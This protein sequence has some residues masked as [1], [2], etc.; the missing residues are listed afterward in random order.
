M[1]SALFRWRFGLFIAFLLGFWLVGVLWFAAW[2]DGSLRDSPRLFAAGL[3]L[4]AICLIFIGF[5]TASFTSRGARLFIELGDR[6]TK[7]F[8]R[9]GKQN[10]LLLGLL[11]VTFAF[12]MAGDYSW[13]FSSIWRRLPLFLAYAGLATLVLKAWMSDLR[14]RQL[15]FASLVFT[16]AVLRLSVFLADVTDYPFSLTWSETTRF[17]YASLFFSERLYGQRIAWP[18]YDASRALLQAIPF[19]FSNLP[20][21]VHRLWQ[22][23]LWMGITVLTANSLTRRLGIGD[24]LQRWVF[25]SATV[26]WFLFAPVY[27]QLQLAVWFVCI[28]LE[29]Y[30]WERRHLFK[31]LL[32]LAIASLWCGLSRINWFP[33]PALIATLFYVLEKPK[34]EQPFYRYFSQPLLWVFFGSMMAAISQGAYIL[35]SG[36]EAHTYGYIFT[37]KILWYRLLPNPTFPTGILPTAIF[38]SFPLLVW[39]V[40]RVKNNHVR[41]GVWRWLALAMMLLVLFAGGIVVSA[42]IGGGNNLHNLDAYWALLWLLAAA[43]YFGHYQNEQPIDR[44][45]MRAAVSRIERL[46]NAVLLGWLFLML[47]F[48]ALSSGAPRFLYSSQDVES[49]LK[50]LQQALQAA[51]AQGPMLFLTERQLLT[52]GTPRSYNIVYD[53]EKVWLIMMAMAHNQAYLDRFHEDIRSQRFSLIVSDPLRLRKKGTSAHFGDENDYWVEEVATPI[54][55]YYE[56]KKLLRT[57]TIR[58]YVPRAEPLPCP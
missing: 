45:E 46:G 24:A 57:A 35:L 47:L 34:G 54:L 3:T 53:Y 36:A 48:S 11:Y 55:C 33:M 6:I 27:F 8:Q 10:L 37:S 39:I 22:A 13:Y 2:R 51:N 31:T 5:L 16:A 12:W 29:R 19:L 38:V 9:L 50:L 43:L 28:G 4:L 1:N 20:L 21:W 49:D 56:P 42:K 14:W 23:V 41:L 40:W 52:F 18:P 17:Y 32:I 7:P 25:F 58:W 44:P 15:G 26:L 30:F